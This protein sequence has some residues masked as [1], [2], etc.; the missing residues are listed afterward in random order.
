MLEGDPENRNDMSKLNQV[1][2]TNTINVL[3]AGHSYKVGN[4]Y[5]Y[6]DE[7]TGELRVT[8]DL[9]FSL[10]IKPNSYNCCK[11]VASR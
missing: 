11:L 1:S 3:E 4:F 5:V 8:T 10:E 7:D 9:K 2:S 6:L